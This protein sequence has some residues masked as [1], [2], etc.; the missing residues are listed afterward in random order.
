[1]N[2]PGY[3]SKVI[4]PDIADYIQRFENINCFDKEP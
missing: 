4:S 1:M 2:E 3:Q